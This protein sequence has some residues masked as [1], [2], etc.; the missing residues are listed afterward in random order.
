[1]ITGRATQHRPGNSPATRRPLL[2]LALVASIVTAVLVIA[3]INFIQPD[4]AR[5]LPGSA[6]APGA[7]SM[8]YG[9][10]LAMQPG[11]AS[12]T[13]AQAATADT[14]A[15]D[16]LAITPDNHLV[17]NRALRDVIDYFL[18]GGL[19]GERPTHIANLLVHLKK[20]LPSPASDDA[21]KIAR[22]YVA[23]LDEHDKLLARESLPASP[24]ANVALAL[25]VDRLSAWTAQRARLRQS[26]LGLDVA[27]VWFGDEE[28]QTQQQLAD[29]RAPG[30]ATT[31][32]ARVETD[33]LQ[34][35]ANTMRTMRTSGA[36]HD[37][38]REQIAAQFGAEAAQRF[39]AFEREDQNWQ[40]RLSNY[41][42]A[43]NQIR[44]QTGTAA[45]DRT[46]QIETLLAN[47]FPAENER[48]RARAL[49]SQ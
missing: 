26:M 44:Q 27:K 14:M 24:Q 48:M 30:N 33:P 38:Q 25:D 32:A 46:Q 31:P 49:D 15:P 7:T 21:T 22:N 42:N 45:T 8:R 12:A 18:L 11:A 6:S 19:P 47:S 1:M 35:A 16:G 34:R 23:Y 37:A 41:R 43:A 40:S 36:S 2:G 39:D 20:T 5:A 10:G 3:V 29:M 9:P 4:D 13:P 28:A 17:I